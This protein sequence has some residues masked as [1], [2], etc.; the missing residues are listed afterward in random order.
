MNATIR[1][2]SEDNKNPYKATQTC[3]TQYSVFFFFFFFFFCF[4]F[5]K[6]KLDILCEL[7]ARQAIHIKCQALFLVK[8]T[9][10]EMSSGL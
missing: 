7:S 6:I 8:L 9:Y 1:L 4:F 5:E 3:S 10:F 2:I